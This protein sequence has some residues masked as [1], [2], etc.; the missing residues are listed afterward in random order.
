M[1]NDFFHL[2]NKS[3]NDFILME[4]KIYFNFLMYKKSV[5]QTDD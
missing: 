2:Q 5:L 3:M 4:E 1:K